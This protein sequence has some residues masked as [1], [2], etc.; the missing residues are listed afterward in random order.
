MNRIASIFGIVGLTILGIVTLEVL[1]D[2]Y[3]FKSIGFKLFLSLLFLG[4]SMAVGDKYE[5]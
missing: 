3:S 4:S 2:V 5:D 1:F